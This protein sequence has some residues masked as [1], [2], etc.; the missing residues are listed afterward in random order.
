MKTAFRHPNPSLQSSWNYAQ[1]GLLIFP[2]IPFIGAVGIVLAI[3]GAWFTQYRTIIRRPLHWGFVLLSVLMLVTV[4][5]AYN[6]TVAFLGLFNFLPFFF[7][8]ASFS[9]LIQTP[10]Q[11]RQMSWILVLSSLPVVILGFGQLFLNWSFKIRILWFVV[12]W[13]IEPGGQPL[14]RMASVFMYANILAGYLMIVFILGIG[15]W[16]EATGV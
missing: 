12:E 13:E 4:S 2:L 11:L 7:V 9:T 6:K 3:L 15:L 1:L 16:V 8:F 14:G 10:A 5:F